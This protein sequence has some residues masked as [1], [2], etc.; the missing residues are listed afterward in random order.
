MNLLPSSSS[1][2]VCLAFLGAI[3]TLAYANEA[4]SVF[5][6]G[7]APGWI[8]VTFQHPGKDGVVGFHVEADKRGVVDA[9]PAPYGP[10][11]GQFV[12]SNLAPSS[13]HTYRVCAVYEESEQ[14]C[15]GWVQ[16]RTLP[17]PSPPSNFNPPIISNFHATP[18]SIQIA[19]GAT[20]TY[21]QIMIRW[22]KVGA[23]ASQPLVENRPNWS[24]TVGDL[25]PATMYHFALK[26]C[27]PQVFTGLSCGPWSPGVDIITPIPPAPWSQPVVRVS[28]Y[29]TTRVVLEF[30]ANSLR[31]KGRDRFVVFRDGEPTQ[32]LTPQGTANPGR[33][34]GSFAH[35]TEK[36]HVYNVCITD[37]DLST[38]SVCSGPVSRPRILR[39]PPAGRVMSKGPSPATS[40][41]DIAGGC[42]P[43]AP[44][45]RPPACKAG[46]VWREAFY[47]DDICVTPQTRAQAAADN[48]QAAAR[49]APS[50]DTCKSGFV[51][52]EARPGDLV[53]VTPETRA[54]A[55]FDNSQARQR[56]V[57]KAFGK[58]QRQ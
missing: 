56:R 1:K 8:I 15:S 2:F 22:S 21:K 50:S 45:P 4:P 37:A 29:S 32:Q 34:T 11:N 41:A 23:A 49:R 6:Q 58:V 35:L 44:V 26:G 38:Q 43:K 33:R 13:D 19:W 39:P 47:G 24:Y 36:I 20:G 55:A 18:T 14:A 46:F 5:A 52:R 54:Q 31:T 3:S 27:T 7:H 53:C 57:P 48:S 12:D 40:C 10:M 51:W 17:P 42:G 30:S 9:Q 25:E 28:E 16:A